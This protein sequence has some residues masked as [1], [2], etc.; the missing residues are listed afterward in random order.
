MYY[1]GGSIEI[2]GYAKNQNRPF[3]S[4]K[5]SHLQNEAKCKTFVVKMSFI[6][7]RITSSNF[8]VNGFTISLALKQRLGATQKWP[9]K[10]HASI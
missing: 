1:N 5:N 7:M 6:C 4:S 9:I 10:F 8:H 3:P 2:N